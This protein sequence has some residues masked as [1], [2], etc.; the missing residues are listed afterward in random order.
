MATFTRANAWNHGGTFDNLDLFWYAKAVGVMKSKPI[1]DPTSWWFYAAIHGEYLTSDFGAGTAPVG[2]PNWTKINSI[3]T[4]ANLGTLP[5]QSLISLFW[6]Q[7]QHGTW[8]FPPW[9]RGYLVALENILRDTIVQLGGPS[10]WSLPYWNYLSQ[11]LTFEENYIPPA[12]TA[13]ELPDGTANPL[14]V[15]ERYGVTGNPSNGIFLIV[16][17]GLSN[18]INDECQWDTLYS[19]G[20]YSQED[21]QTPPDQ[22]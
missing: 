2:Y 7:C 22:E 1:S 8:F 4:T 5:K 9:H 20:D 19:S 18:S 11:S 13:A 14:Y 3:P 21:P 12:F 6:N 10:D 17:T 15:S 16:G